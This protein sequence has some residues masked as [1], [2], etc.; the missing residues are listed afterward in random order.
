M[1]A[2]YYGENNFHKQMHPL[3]K[4]PGLHWTDGVFKKYISTHIPYPGYMKLTINVLFDPVKK[5]LEEQ[6]DTKNLN[7]FS[8][9]IGFSHL[10]HLP[11][12]ANIHKLEL[13]NVILNYIYF[14]FETELPIC[15]MSFGNE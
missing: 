12:I 10:F 11:F 4:E 14:L 8:N 15:R 13:F 2:N 9:C 6:K 3:N 5:G 1:I 7:K